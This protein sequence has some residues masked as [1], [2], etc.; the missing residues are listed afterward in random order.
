MDAET[1]WRERERKRAKRLRPKEKGR[2]TSID[3]V[4]LLGDKILTLTQAS[5]SRL[6]CFLFFSEFFSLEETR[7]HQ[8]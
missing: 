4:F 6:L 5:P 2:E 8:I 7:P 3:L 1:G